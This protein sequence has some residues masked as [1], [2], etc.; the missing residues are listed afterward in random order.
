MVTGSKE[1][2]L[3]TTPPP[4]TQALTRGT[5][6]V[7]QPEMNAVIRILR[8]MSR[9]FDFSVCSHSIVVKGIEVSEWKPTAAE[10]RQAKMA[11][12]ACHLWRFDP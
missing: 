10:Q 1:I 4:L 7:R 9:G 2:P 5:K 6:R 3:T 11:K 8:R 12:R